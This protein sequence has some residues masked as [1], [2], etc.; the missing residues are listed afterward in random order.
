MAT[1]LGSGAALAQDT[2]SVSISASGTPGYAT[3][4]AVPPGIGGMAPQLALLYTASNINGPVGVGWTLQGISAITRCGAN[5]QIDGVARAVAYSPDDKLCLDG[6]RLIQV[7]ASGV[8][9]NDAVQNPNVSNPFQ[10]GD[11]LGGSGQVREYRTEKDIYSRIRAY[12]SAGGDPANGP[13]YF[14]VWTKSGQVFEYGVNANATSNAAITASGKNIVTTWAVSRISDTVGNYI[15]FRYSQRESTWGTAAGPL[16]GYAGREWNLVEVRYTGNGGQEPLNRIVLTYTER[17]AVTGDRAEAFHQGSKTVNLSRLEAIR[18]YVNWPASQAERPQSAVKVKTYKIAYENGPRSGR[19]RVTR[20]VECGGENENVCLP[21]PT[22]EYSDGSS[23]AF[24]ANPA[25]AASALASATLRDTNGKYGVLTGS[26]FGSGRTDLIRWS[27]NPAENQLYRSN[28]DGTFAQVPNGSGPGQ[29]NLTD[30]NLA[31]ADGCYSAE[32]ADFNGDGAA[33]IL[34][35]MKTSAACG[36]ARNLLF[37][38]NGDGSFS[39]RELPGIELSRTAAKITIRPCKYNCEEGGMGTN[40]RTPGQSFYLL[41]LNN[42]GLLDIVTA[43]HPGWNINVGEVVEESDLCGGIVCTQVYMQQLDGAFVEKTNTNVAH[44]ILYVMPPQQWQVTGRA[45]AYVADFNGDGLTD[46]AAEQHNWLSRGDGD[47]DE[48]SGTESYCSHLLDFNGDGRMDCLSPTDGMPAYNGLALANGKTVNATRNFNLKGEGDLLL[49]KTTGTDI[50]T[51]DVAPLD[52]DGD[53]RSDILRVGDDAAMNTVFLSN[54][55]GTFRRADD[56]N[57]TDKLRSSDGKVDFIVGDFTGQGTVELLRVTAG[58]GNVLY[59]KQ[60]PT[61]PDQLRSVTSATGLKTEL[62]WVT[63]THPFTGDQ[64]PRYYHDFKTSSGAVYPLRDV[65]VPMSVVARTVADSGVRAEKQ[66]TDYLYAGLK[67]SYNGL[68]ML[69]FREVRQQTRTTTGKALTVLNAYLQDGYNTGLAL[70][71]R[72]WI[73]D[74]WGRD[75]SPEIISE[76][77]NIYCDKTAAA[78]ALENA[79]TTGSCVPGSRVRRPFL[80]VS[81][82]RGW[83]KGVELPTVQTVN[84]YNDDGDP[85]EIRQSISGNAVGQA[86]HFVK[87]TTNTYYPANKSDDKWLLGRLQRATVTADHRSD[88]QGAKQA[89]RVPVRSAMRQGAASALP[90][91]ATQ[92]GPGALGVVYARDVVAAVKST[93]GSP[94][95]IGKVQTAAGSAPYA[96]ANKGVEFAVKIDP[97][98]VNAYA[99]VAGMLWASPVPTVTGG[100]PPYRYQWTA[101]DA[102]RFLVGGEQL[103]SPVLSAVMAINE[104]VVGTFKLTVRDAAQAEISTIVKVTLTASSGPVAVTIEPTTLRAKGIKPGMVSGKVTATANGGLGHTALPGRAF[105]AHAPPS[106]TPRSRTP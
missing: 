64:D 68:G 26:F 8:V 57:L 93:S 99:N 88:V 25:F 66:I 92:Q 4:I 29:F 94:D 105:P 76:T 82:E 38:S 81:S 21:A 101:I 50:R 36:S 2:Q 65:A 86:Q 11:S 61:P 104:T 35:T 75:G 60:N 95:S 56:F 55:D 30:V 69:G 90:A 3:Q 19:S 10:T 46:I 51:V 41:D 12:G 85:T 40:Q 87:T 42:D 17:G 59:V 83:E 78:G 77:W 28:G 80:Y 1:F 7:D 32:V 91:P 16:D 67:A 27:E 72:T 37:I 39:A 5:K 33:D 103:A 18:T 52:I 22:F 23:A 89:A 53:G 63:L 49:R 54:G 100:I 15:D 62:T 84:T 24:T 48:S 97:A 102:P 6:Q 34:R 31:K 96:S 9:V 106:R 47:F 79:Y 45:N 20:I 73:G 44:R 14:K 43:K 70:L 13:A 98:T 71:T 74:L 58:G